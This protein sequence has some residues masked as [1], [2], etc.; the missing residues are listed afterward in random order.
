MS[1]ILTTDGS[2]PKLFKMP[3]LK[4]LVQQRYTTFEA[5]EIQEAV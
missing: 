5:L 4:Y 3:A 2:Y 1:N